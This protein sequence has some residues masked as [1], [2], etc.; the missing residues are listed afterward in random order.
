M[1][2]RQR[3]QRIT[4]LFAL[5]TGLSGLAVLLFRFTR[6]RTGVD[7]STLLAFATLALITTYFRVQIG[8]AGAEI[9]LT[10]AILLGATLAGGPAL[11][12]WV[13][14]VVG[15]T[16][17]LPVIRSGAPAGQH[18]ARAWPRLAADALFHGGRNVLAVE[19]AWAAYR[20]LGGRAT[21]SPRSLTQTT[22]VVV[23]C[24]TYAVARLGWMWLSRMLYDVARPTGDS[25]PGF[26]D[27]LVETLP[28]PTAL[29]TAAVFD[30][31]G[32]SFF[33]LLAFLYIGFGALVHQLQR[34]IRDLQD[35]IAARE[36]ADQ[37]QQAI[38]SAPSEL[39]A[40]SARAYE[41]CHQ[42]APA[43]HCEL[44]L[45]DNLQTHVR[46]LISVQ[47][48]EHLPPMRIPL[49][50][51]WEWLRGRTE[52]CVS[53]N[54]PQIELLPFAMPAASRDQPT[55]SAILAPICVEEEPGAYNCLGGIVLLSPDPDTF[56]PR[57]AR[58]IATLT[59]H[60]ARA[61]AA[62]QSRS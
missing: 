29:L 56:G 30:R 58:N 38:A 16:V 22:A 11:G 21:L 39:S 24:L 25:A 40:L 54:R 18:R 33:L 42:L 10:G 37:I 47:E 1:T 12:G 28:L 35:D 13:A 32:W 48:D 7:L 19:A 59:A 57:E 9:G 45:L 36:V 17:G 5:L 31:L 55:Q 6:Q 52:I 44:G 51:L 43:H 23:L 14:F 2:N 20:G 62:R 34:H 46:I 26:G 4:Y 15:L 60:L 49:T 50:P 27:L 8:R 3:G 53:H 41:I 61:L